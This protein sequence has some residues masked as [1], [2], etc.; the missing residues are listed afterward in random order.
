MKSLYENADHHINT[1]K[2]FIRMASHQ[3]HTIKVILADDHSRVRAGMRS[4][5]ERHP[6]IVVVAEASDGEEALRKVEE[7]QPDILLLDVEMPFM[8]GRQVATTI[9][10]RALPVQ[11]LAVSAYDDQHYIQGMLQSG[12]AGYITKDEVPDLLLE[13]VEGIARGEEGWVSRRV[14]K[15]IAS[16]EDN[17]DSEQHT[18]TPRELEVL[19][20]LKEKKSNQA[21]AADLGISLEV[22]NLH[23]KLLMAKLGVNTRAELVVKASH[24]L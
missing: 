18:L 2:K 22:V 14:A 16:W 8:N 20:L 7:H 10:Q 12:A 3:Q 1:Q 19:Q 21:I 5:L 15:K 9:K 17:L 23:V 13:A 11:I 6:H 24:K 4:I